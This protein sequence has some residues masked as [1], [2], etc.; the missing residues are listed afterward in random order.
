TYKKLDGNFE[1]ELI[2][3]EKGEINLTPELNTLA[4][5]VY[6][7]SHFLVS[8][9]N[10]PEILE[11]TRR[12]IYH[13]S[14]EE[15]KNIEEFAKKKPY[16][17]LKILIE[18]LRKI[19]INR[20]E[21]FFIAI[22]T[23]E[24]SPPYE[25][26]RRICKLKDVF[27]A[28]EALNLEFQIRCNTKEKAFA[29][30]IDTEH[31]LSNAFNVNSEIEEL[32]GYVEKWKNE[33]YSRVAIYHI[34]VPKPYFGTTHIPFDIGSDEQ[35]LIYEYSFKLKKAGFNDEKKND[36]ERYSYLIFERG[37]GQLPFQFL[38]T[39]LLALRIIKKYLDMNIEPDEIEKK[40]EYYSEFFGFDEQFIKEREI[41]FQHALDPLKGMIVWPEEAHTILGKEAIERF[42]KRPEEWAS[43]EYK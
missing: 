9:E 34:G 29:A 43:E 21:A 26:L 19:G 3:I 41:I 14:E 25:G 16:E 1:K 42:R 12:R 7:I 39:V 40:K 5:I 36:L 31:L 33:I 28:S 32:I 20:E 18:E 37:G 2:D 35:Y 38:R 4:S 8:I 30:C 24:A 11:E 13:L 22:E 23:P 10:F 27:I 17:K 6:S 15:K